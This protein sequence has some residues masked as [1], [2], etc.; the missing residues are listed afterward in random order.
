MRRG[1]VLGMLLALGGL[2]WP[3]SRRSRRRRT[4]RRWSRSRRSRTTS[5]CCAAR[6]RRQHRRL[7]HR[8][9][10]RRRRR[11]EPR[12]GQADPRQDQGADAEA[13]DDA[14]QHA[15]ARRPCQRQ[16][17]VPGDGRLRR[18][19][20][21]QGQHGEDADLQGAQRRRHGQADVQGQDDDRQGRRSDRPLLLRP[22]PHQRRR[23]GGLPGAAHRA[24]RRH[25]RGQ[26]GAAHRRRPTA[27]ACCTTPRR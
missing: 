14:D 2:R 22:R 8:Q 18:A 20:K 9:R 11:Q 7:R 15:H 16:R 25:L 23:V 12:L 19:G 27:A 6:R 17:G 24:R 4:R 1:I 13:G 21:H 26:G 10:R 3:P 5:T